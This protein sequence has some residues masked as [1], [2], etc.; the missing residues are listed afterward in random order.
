[1]SKVKR[2][3]VMWLHGNTRNIKHF[4]KV[5]SPRLI[6][7]AACARV[8]GAR[9]IDYLVALSSLASPSLPL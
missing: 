8:S 3:I 5:T 9:G 2:D 4:L 7:I 1:M 6:V